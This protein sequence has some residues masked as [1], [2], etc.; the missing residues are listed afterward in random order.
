MAYTP[1]TDFVGL[2]RSTAG[3]AAKSEMPGLD[4]VVAALNRTGLIKIV[5]AGVP[6][7]V[8]QTTTA[9]FQPSSPSFSSEGILY[10]WDATSSSYKPAT[11]A[12]FAAY[13][14]VALGA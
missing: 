12:L 11:P 5:T 8:N 7:T 2:W 3:G 4:F 9:W 14:Q 1:N 10:L 6:P 13:L